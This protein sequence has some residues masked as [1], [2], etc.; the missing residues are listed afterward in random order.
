MIR[1]FLVYAAISLVAVLALGVVLAGSYR[2]DARDRGLAEG[3]S[4]ASLV[5]QTAIEP[6]LD[7]TPLSDRLGPAEQVALEGLVGRLVGT[8]TVLRLRLRDVQGRVVFS[9][10]GS[11]VNEIPDD[12]ALEAAHGAVITNLTD[13]NTDSNDSGRSGVQVV[14]VYRP[15]VAGPG[16]QIVGVLEIYLPYSPINQDVSAGLDRLYRDL[17]IGLAVLWL[18]LLGI[19]TSVTRGLR[20]QVVLNAF[21]AEHD[22]LTGL[23][24]RRLFERRAKEAIA[25]ALRDDTSVTIAIVDLDRFKE[26]ND[27][28]GHRSGDRVLIELARR[29]ID[30]ASAGDTVA[31]LGGDEFGLILLCAADPDSLGLRIRTVTAPVVEIDG[32]HLTIEASA[33]FVVAPTDGQDAQELLQRADVALY[34]AKSKQLDATRYNSADDHYDPN[35][36]GLIAEL[37][38]GIDAGQLVLHFQPMMRAVDGHVGAVE[39]LV[40]WNHP[41]RGLLGP[42]RFIPLAEQTDLV[43]QLTTWVLRAAL[44]GLRD[45]GA[46]GEELEV[47]VNVSARNLS[48]PDFAR[49]V[50]RTIEEVGVAP[51]RL[52]I[53]ITE[54]ALLTDPVRAASVVAELSAAGVKV[55]LD[56]FGCG[57]TSL[58]YLSTLPVHELKI[59]RIF[60]S[61]M[62]DNPTHDVIVR[63]I[64]DLGHNLGLRVVGEGVETHAVL[65]HLR[66]AGCDVAQGFLLA[67]PMPLGQ[68]RVWLAGVPVAGVIPAWTDAIATHPLMIDVR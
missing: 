52:V 68:L 5:A 37:R 23:P 25:A 59:D 17:A 64:V 48:R 47:A 63:S 34:V 4:K 32:L 10:D 53:E 3:R 14:E 15:L 30:S 29:L 31:R 21:L 61:D 27:T 60:V 51:G 19:C 11:G 24:N 28:L 18:V 45:L 41:T 49:H 12:E 2:T 46:L 44:C 66:S 40:R 13:L 22:P 55:S 7:G 58:G 42:D 8:R 67:R 6:L 43:D 1:L 62:V 57:Q 26:I 56:D 38:R 35:N 39:A 20:R 9:D 50:I 16:S 65:L 54:T 33:G 36:L